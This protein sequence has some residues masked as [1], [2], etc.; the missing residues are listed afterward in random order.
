MD[1]PFTESKE[2]VAGYTLIQVGL[3]AEALRWAERFPNPGDTDGEIEV[4]QLFELDDFQP[5]EAI[6]RFREMR[7]DRHV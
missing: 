1:G 5:S 7:L 6:E 3:R 4:R 2:L